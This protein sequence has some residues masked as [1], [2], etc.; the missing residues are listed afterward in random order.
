M[1]IAIIGAN[2]FVGAALCRY[3]FKKGHEIIA[4]GNQDRPSPN[5]LKIASY[6]KI[7]ISKV[8]PEIEADVCIHT[9]ALPSDTDTY[10]SLIISNVEGT[11]NVVEAAKNCSH[12]IHISSSSVY[13]FN[14]RPVSEDEA[15]I[16]AKLS[17]YGE[18]KLLAEDIMDLNIPPDQKR[19]ILRP[20]VIYGIGD[21]I[22]LP[23]ILRLVRGK[24]FLCPLRKQIK[25]SLTHI[26]N[27][28]YAIDLFIA[29]KNSAPLQIYNIADAEPYSL[30]EILLQLASAVEKR[31]LILLPIPATVLDIFL[32]LNSKTGIIKNISQ[33][34]LRSTNTNTVLDIS[35][36]TKELNYI[37]IKSFYNSY[38]E[39]AK[40]IDS[41]G[42]RKN[43]LKQLP[44]APWKVP[45]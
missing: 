8:I 42:G 31:K 5:L 22:L 28:A 20:R 27:V 45:F 30:R 1:K 7:D 36:I 18:T 21:R 40:W 38:T 34:V 2:G 9:A 44:Y 14:N 16:N 19:L 26:D 11:L 13:Q 25:T 41:F 6:T 4:L 3:F 24:F 32:I 12:L 37:P 23:R 17:D 39:I 43:Y 15:T 33:P 10:K 35:R 29:K